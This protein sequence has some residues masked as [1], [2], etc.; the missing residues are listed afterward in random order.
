[1][2]A[3]GSHADQ[4]VSGCQIFTGNH[5]FLVTYADSK[6]CQIVL[7]LRHQARMLCGLTADQCRIGLQ[8]AFCNAF[9]DRS[10]LLRIVLSACDVVEEEQRFSAGTCDI[11][12]THGNGINADGVVFIKNHGELHL[13]SAS[14]CTGKQ[15]RLF[16]F[17]DFCQ[18]KSAGKTAK[19]A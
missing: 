16:H 5:V 13:G 18:G 15:H 11:I 14:V 12:H 3:G 4:Y 19:A 9:Y 1:M 8:T 2:N 17:F 6:T 10:Y 7:I